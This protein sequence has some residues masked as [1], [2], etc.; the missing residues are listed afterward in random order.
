M[1][2]VFEENARSTTLRSEGTFVKTSRELSL[3]NEARELKR[4]NEL[5]IR[6]EHVRAL[7]YKDYHEEANELVTVAVPGSQTLFNKLWNES[8]MVARAC[9]KTVELDKLFSRAEEIGEWLRQPDWA[10]SAA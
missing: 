6:T 7:E 2:A 1:S 8:S 5:N 10:L 4:C 9:R 3:I